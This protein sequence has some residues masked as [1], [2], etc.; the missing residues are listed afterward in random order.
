VTGLATQ[1]RLLLSTIE[2]SVP[3]FIIML[4]MFHFSGAWWHTP[5]IPA[6]GRQRQADFWVRGQPGLQSE[7]QESQVY[8]EKLCPPPKKNQPK[9]RKQQQQKSSTSLSLPSDDHIVTQCGG[10]SC[11]LAMQLLV[12]LWLTSSI[13]MWRVSKH[14]S[15]CACVAY[16]RAGLWWHIHMCLPFS[17]H[18]ELNGS[19]ITLLF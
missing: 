15:K 14:V 5:L 4:K 8:T 1:N 16:W 9:N 7:F 12:G 13:H 17:L 18:T 2:S 11:R 6:L 10:F 19:F 3:S